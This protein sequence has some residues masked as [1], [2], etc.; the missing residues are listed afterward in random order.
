MNSQI[1]SKQAWTR[2]AATIPLP[3]RHSPFQLI[4][5][6]IS[7]RAVIAAIVLAGPLARGDLLRVYSLDMQGLDPSQ[8]AGSTGVVQ[9]TVSQLRPLEADVIILNNVTGWDMCNEVVQAL[10]PVEYHVA[11]C[12]SFVDPKTGARSAQQTAILSNR[13]G[14][15]AWSE[16]W[17][18]T[19]TASAGG[20]AFAAIQTGKQ[21]VGF[22]AVQ[23]S[24]KF[25]LAAISGQSAGSPSGEAAALQQWT[26]SL[27]LFKKW[28]AN[29]LDAVVV[30]AA[31]VRQAPSARPLQM[32]ERSRFADRFLN[33]GL[34]QS[35]SLIKPGTRYYAVRLPAAPDDL[36]GVITCE[37]GVTCDLDVD[38]A[39]P[40][41]AAIVSSGPSLEAASQAAANTPRAWN[42]PDTW[43]F[44]A[45][46]LAGAI[47]ATL[48][49]LVAVLFL[50]RR[51]RHARLDRAASRRLA[52]SAGDVESDTLVVVPKS[53]TA[54]GQSALPAPRADAVVPGVPP[55]TRTEFQPWHKS[56][57]KESASEVQPSGLAA[58]VSQWLKERLVRRLLEDRASMIEN[59]RGAAQKTDLVNERLSR[60]E[61]QLRQQHRA[62]ELRIEALTAELLAAKEENRALIRAKIA[63]VKA[64]MESARARLMAENGED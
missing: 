4:A 33:A 37:P 64:E 28:V 14:Y 11:V 30:M 27:D 25:V 5:S 34:R 48:S 26:G 19:A 15:F 38:G 24:D 18:S 7:L 35:L 6:W 63:Q 2:R 8:A 60:I 53:I 50:R 61:A 31:V 32:V 9:Q 58:L 44:P 52:L 13:K 43:P 57:G 10:K 16:P 45:L 59:Q 51:Q 12:S 21:R 62:Y 54:S 3:R 40:P 36:A 49:F 22:Y 29:R 41:A 56:A 42:R 23:V 46:W 47:I 17:H 39:N 55:A 1:Q 20:F